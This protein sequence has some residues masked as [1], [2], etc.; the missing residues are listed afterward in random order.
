MKKKNDLVRKI[1][2]IVLGGLL[3][4]LLCASNVRAL[5]IP[6][7]GETETIDYYVT[8]VDGLPDMLEIYGTAILEGDAAAVW[9][10]AFPGKELNEPGSTVHI[11]G[12]APNNSL[13]VLEP[14]S[15]WQGLDAVV[16]VYGSRFKIG[17]LGSSFAPPVDMPINGWLYVLNELDEVQFSIMIYSD[18][19]IHLRAPDSEEPEQVEAELKTSPSLM[20][21]N[22]RSPV[23]CA[24]IRLPEG[25]K[26]DDVDDDYPLMIYAC[27]N[28][29]GV[30]A[31]YKRIFQS[32]RQED[33]RVKIFAFFN[34]GT[35]L[36]SLSEDCEQMQLQVR[37]RLKA[38]KEF[39]GNDK[40]K[41]VKPRRRHWTYM[42]NWKSR[43]SY[44][45]R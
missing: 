43:R 45:H 44:R 7:G 12:C 22:R 39:Y 8:T 32:C 16:N 31:K 29:A 9:I 34:V 26:K 15:I 17:D 27:E 19:N 13:S 6:S 42:K 33:S 20:S 37:G 25:I 2:S 10:Y 35:L 1:S 41:I 30:E 28:G 40:I 21:R 38:E 23:V 14:S 3:A 18:V 5:S 36:Q 4:I 11:Y 24:M